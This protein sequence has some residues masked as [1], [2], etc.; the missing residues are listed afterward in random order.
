MAPSVLSLADAP[1]PPPVDALLRLGI[2]YMPSSA[3]N[4]VVSLGIA[5]R[6][7]AGPRTVP[8]LARE[9]SANEDALY[10]VMR[11]LASEGV[12]EEVAPRAFAHSPLSEVLRTGSRAG[13]FVRRMAEPI[14]RVP[15]VPE[16]FNGKVTSQR[17]MVVP[18]VL[19]AYDFSGIEVLVDVAGGHGKVLTSVLKAYPT[20][21]G[22]LFDLPFVV[23]GAR[24]AIRA[25]GLQSRCRAEAGDMFQAVPAGG[26]AYI[27]KHII[28]DWDDEGA[29]A[30]LVN[31]RA[32]MHGGRGKVLLLESVAEP[33]G[34]ERSEPDFRALLA[35][36]GFELTRVVRTTSPLSIV[37]AEAR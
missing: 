28:Q 33:G 2:G 10:R 9:A 26:D 18:A 29:L 36:A 4:V 8:D 11:M 17:A 13:E 14:G 30:I 31:V 27:M 21:R 12:F 22:V 6:L 7:A 1:P 32:A 3:L 25:L 37:E 20:M 15:E 16:V 19:E 34:H 5:E 24:P 23:E 35:R